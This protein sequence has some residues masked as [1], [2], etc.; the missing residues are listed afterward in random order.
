M[1]EAIT[2]DKPHLVYKTTTDSKVGPFVVGMIPDRAF[3]SMV[4]RQIRDALNS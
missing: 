4:L 1:V 3:D 2:A